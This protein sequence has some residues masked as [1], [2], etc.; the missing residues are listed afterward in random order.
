MAQIIASTY[1]IIEKIGSGGGGVV[2][3][4]NHTRLNKR[5]VL[6]ADKRKI[7]TR[8]EILRREVDALKDLSHTYIPQVYD[9][10]VEDDTVYT[11]IDYIEG[12]SLDRPLKRGER[13]TQP[14][15]IKWA[16]QLLEALAYLHKPIH[17]T[18]PRGIVHSDIKPANIMLKSNGD[19][20]L[21]D[22]NI[23]LALGEENVVGLSAGYA[24]P[25]H[26][27]LDFSRDTSF[28]TGAVSRSV[29]KGTAEKTFQDD[30]T[31]TM[32]SDS[33][34]TMAG[35]DE[36]KVTV[37]MAMN[38][39]GTGS[40]S[41]LK[42]IVVPD[43]RSDIYSLGATLYHLISGVKPAKNAAEVI[44]L[45]GEGISPLVADIIKKAMQPNPDMRYQSA[46]E[47]LWDFTHLRENDPR[48]IRRKRIRNTA[49]AVMTAFMAAS[50]FVSFTGLKRM[51]AEKSSLALAAN[52]RNAL[53]SGNPDQAVE[54][55]LKAL[56]KSGIFTPA[57]TAE[58]EKALAD[59]SGVYNLS[60][61]FR[62]YH[63]KELPSEI[64]KICLSPDGKTGAA[65]YSFAA[66][67]F[68]T[69]TGKT[70]AELPL[71]QSALSDVVFVN[72]QL[73]AYA[74]DKGLTLYDITKAADLWNGEAVT[75]IAVSSDG[76]TI[77]GIYKNESKAYIYDIEGN[78][79]KVIDFAGKKQNV[80]ENDFFADPM[81]NL[82][83]LSDDGRYLAVS[84][85]DGGIN[86]F[87]TENAE[88]DITIFDNSDYIHFEG[89]FCGKYFAFSGSNENESE[90]IIADTEELVITQ[91]FVADGKISVRTDED[92]I[93]LSNLS[94]AV[95]INPETGEQQELAYTDSDIKDFSVYKG[96]VLA[97][98]EKN[99]CLF[100]KDGGRFFSKIAPVQADFDFVDISADFAVAAGR[101][102]SG[103]NIFKA[104]TNDGAE[105]AVYDKT[106]IHD[107]ARV[108]SDRTKTMLFDYKGFRL[109]T[110]DGKLINSVMLPDPEAVY[111]EQYCH[112]SGNL[113]VMYKDAFRLYSGEDGR[114][115][116]EAD[117]LRSVFYAP[118]GVSI[119]TDEGELKLIDLDTAEELFSEKAQGDFAVYCGMV[120]DSEF[121]NGRKIIGAGKTE[122]GYYFAVA[123]N[124]N[125][126]VYSHDGK[127][128]FT[129]PVSE[130]TEAFFTE[131]EIIISPTHGT[132]EVY[133]LDGGSKIADLDTDAYLTYMTPVDEY[134]VS[135]YISTT[136]GAYGILLD[137]DTYKPLAYLPGLADIQ[138]NELIFDYNGGSLRKSAIYTTDEL[139]AITKGGKK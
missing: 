123:D 111:D 50:L 23:A 65:T 117:N 3:L 103:V 40:I 139:I 19:I 69:E 125:C 133:R 51:E 73:I 45:S 47:M 132:P 39:S 28:T 33:T 127:E 77:A 85:D 55:A 74:G 15:V 75:H 81:D 95:K 87:D 130:N 84:F 97:L 80:V 18:P 94:T 91:D 49:A 106:D 43:A 82:L 4:A 57:Y 46:E 37:T 128:L 124:E 98:T 136:E 48:T 120:V 92:G 38:P 1:E 122:K 41:S 5:V 90:F 78:R 2:Y 105:I 99:E 35:D 26:Y 112:N 29:S 131:G 62:A 88:G 16:V 137:K 27:G 70:K 63:N 42:K 34:M 104:V 126:C 86:L 8:P 31:K 14:Q 21:I 93:Y 115:I 129:V 13:F 64:F 17:G 58:A 9:F 76:Q 12:E 60:D 20:C 30:S 138:D 107:E 52:S 100:Y 68:D 83:K 119:Y 72:D 36:E 54:L 56:P 22:F 10:F 53:E 109:Y 108:N 121:L 32:P 71:A 102:K 101:N 44:P 96:T 59:S 89:G 7:T 134:V 114:A 67:I 11:V 24:S 116:Y 61:S 135:Q 118:Y 79:R 113:A 110:S 66:V 6:K 25:E